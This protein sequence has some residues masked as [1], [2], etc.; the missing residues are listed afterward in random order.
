[1]TA[2]DGC[3][4]VAHRWMSPRMIGAAA[5]AAAAASVVCHLTSI[6]C[7]QNEILPHD[8]KHT[9][10]FVAPQSHHTHTYTPYTHHRSHVSRHAMGRDAQMRMCMHQPA[11]RRAD[12]RR[13]RASLP[14]SQPPIRRPPP[15]S[16]AAAHGCVCQHVD[17]RLAHGDCCVC[18]SGDGILGSSEWSETTQK[19]KDKIGSLLNQSSDSPFGTVI[20]AAS[21]CCGNAIPTHFEGQ[22]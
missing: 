19:A 7:Q 1:M 2:T 16:A 21:Y 9:D 15:R 13:R 6:G 22:I 18:V 4:S 8:S 12:S 14:P 20:L 17:S 10:P 5:A 11:R 3:V